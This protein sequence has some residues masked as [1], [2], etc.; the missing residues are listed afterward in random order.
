MKKIG[1]FII[2]LNAVADPVFSQVKFS[3]ETRKY[4][5][6][7][8]SVTVFVHALLIDGKGNTPKPNQAIIISKGKIDWIGD[9]AKAVIP[10]GA[11]TI[12]LKGKAIMPGLVM[13]HEH[14]YISAHD[15]GTR[16][17]HLKQLPYTFPR[18]YLAA[19]ATTIR[20]CGSVEPYSD[21]RIKKDIDLGLLPGPSIELTAPYIEGPS[22]RFPQMKENKTP[23]EAAA[24]VNY[25]AD[26]GFTSFKA[27]MGVDQPILKAAIDAAHKRKLKI[28]GHL[29]KVTYQEAAALGMDNLEHGFIASTDFVVGKKENEAPATGA[30]IKSLANL[31]IQSDSVQQFIQFLVNRK[32]GITSS[33]AVFEGATTTQPRPDADAINAMAADAKDFYLQRFVSVKS[34]TAPTDMDKA[35]GKA[36]K[37]EKMFYDRGGLLTVGTDPTGIGGTIAGYGNWRAIELLVEADGFTPLEAIKIATLNGAI[38]LDAEKSTGTIETGKA[39]DLLII[40]GDPSKNI[41]DIRKVQ[42]VFKNGVGYNSA[43]L[44]ASVKGKVGFN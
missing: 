20:T 23:E 16:Y 24:F 5:E 35:F 39:A 28:T 42:V 30:A 8:D 29:D 4:I 37:M 26:Q 1:L 15:I 43:R 27:Y 44:F 25:W 3:D 36:A 13:L 21:I 32:V 17:L 19:G 7:N 11:S 12:D 22:S 14:M 10:K 33:L 31:D 2:F 6:Y 34:A 18:L 40:D 9:D 41:K 38:A